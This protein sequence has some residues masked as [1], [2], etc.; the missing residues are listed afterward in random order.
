MASVALGL[1]AQDLEFPNREAASVGLVIYDLTNHRY[2]IE[3]NKEQALLPAST[4]KAVTTA[5]ALR[6]L[7]RNFKFT[8]EVYAIGNASDSVFN[9]RIVIEASGDPTIDSSHFSDY[10]GFASDIVRALCSKGFESGKLKVEVES[11]MPDE[12]PNGNWLINDLGHGYGAG[13]FGFNYHDNLFLLNSSSMSFSPAYPEAK[14]KFSSSMSGQSVQHGINSN[15]YTVK[16][17][18]SAYVPMDYPADVFAYN[19]SNKLKTE[20]FKIAKSD[21]S[22]DSIPLD[23][24]LLLKHNSPKLP[25][26]ARSLM[27]RSDNMMAEGMLRAIAPESPRSVAISRELSIWRDEGISVSTIQIEDGSGL[28]RRD[29]LTPQFLTEMLTSM[30]E[31]DRAQLYL[32]FFPRVGQEGTVK[33]LLAGTPLAGNLA[34]KSGS[35][36]GVQCYAGYKLDEDDKPT[37]VVVVMVNGFFCQ[38]S[39]LKHGIERFLLDTFCNSEAPEEIQI[40]EPVIEE[41]YEYELESEQ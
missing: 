19:L 34:L 25:S 23:K 17:K 2:V 3:E 6:L 39:T 28:S 22:V 7:G 31:S 1:S 10:G 40:A 9:G 35:M 20:G 38:R 14:I 21:P 27:V 24:I 41:E 5:S 37:H 36:N 30:A 16:G 13:I 33:G 8:T 32:S 26:I 11:R 4:M 12:G 15:L 18:V 29:R